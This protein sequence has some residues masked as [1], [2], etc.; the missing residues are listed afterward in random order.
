MSGVF[1]SYC[2]FVC[3]VLRGNLRARCFTWVE[4]AD[5]LGCALMKPLEHYLC[6]S[7]CVFTRKHAN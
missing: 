6:P 2:G 3:K 4:A 5:V 1:L 7:P